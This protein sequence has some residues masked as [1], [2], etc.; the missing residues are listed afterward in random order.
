MDRN[1]KYQ[2]GQQFKRNNEVEVSSDFKQKVELIALSHLAV[3]NSGDYMLAMNSLAKTQART[4]IEE[5]KGI[6]QNLVAALA[7]KEETTE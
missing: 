3:G 6:V 1:L 7:P 5:L 4:E 2:M